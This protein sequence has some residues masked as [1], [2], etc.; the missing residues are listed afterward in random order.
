MWK[1]NSLQLKRTLNYFQLLFK[2]TDVSDT[3]QCAGGCRLQPK[4][5]KRVFGI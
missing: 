2:S 5:D 3:A 1:D 4:S